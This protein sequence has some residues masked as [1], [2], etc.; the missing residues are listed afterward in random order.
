MTLQGVPGL[1]LTPWWTRSHGFI[2]PLSPKPPKK[3]HQC[4]DQHSVEQKYRDTLNEKIQLHKEIK[5][6]HGNQAKLENALEYNSAL[7]IKLENA[8]KQYR[9]RERK[10]L[11]KDASD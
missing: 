2:T 10:M 11:R 8:L 6:L 4:V 7:I 1:S 5:I 3:D 9:Y